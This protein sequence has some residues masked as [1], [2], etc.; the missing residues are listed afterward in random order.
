MTDSTPGKRRWINLGELIALGALIISALGVW[1]AWKSNSREDKQA[2]VV[3][4][5]QPIPLTLRGSIEQD[6][7]QLVISPIEPGHALESMT[8]SIEGASPIEVGSDGALAAS[9]LESALEG[10]EENK[11]D[12]SVTARIVTRYV[13]AGTDRRSSGNYVIRYRWEGGGLFGGRT[14]KLT[15]FSRA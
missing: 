11:G 7:R 5:R 13:E 10:R 8:V 4:Q 3:E 15:G 9:D 14:L 6:G 12:H 2:T 1:I